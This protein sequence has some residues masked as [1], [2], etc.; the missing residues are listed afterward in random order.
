M[1]NINKY[2]RYAIV[3]LLALLSILK[4]MDICID[5]NWGFISCSLI[6]IAIF[7]CVYG[8]Y[9]LCFI[10]AKHV[11]YAYANVYKNK[12]IPRIEMQAIDRYIAEHPIPEIQPEEETTE[13][14][15]DASNRLKNAQMNLEQFIAACQMERKAMMAE[16]EKADAEKLEKILLYTRQTFMKFD[17]TDEE[18]YQLNECVKTFVTLHAVLPAVNVHIVKKRI[19]SQGDLKNFSWNIA[20]HITVP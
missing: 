12:V 5:H 11:T 7:G 4:A 18:L 9:R 14:T 13:Q 19:L 3:I 17:F 16:K 8:F 6:S 10:I 2:L 1:D 15:M 20:N